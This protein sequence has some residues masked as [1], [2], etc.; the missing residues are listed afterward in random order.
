MNKP[1]DRVQLA[2]SPPS[3]MA[4]AS[5][6]RIRSPWPPSA[7][8]PAANTSTARFTAWPSF[9]PLGSMIGFKAFA[10][11]EDS[12]VRRFPSWATVMQPRPWS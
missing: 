4:D 12:G 8:V 3:A 10:C 11:A 1:R 6:K 5:C 2:A 7:R 9:D